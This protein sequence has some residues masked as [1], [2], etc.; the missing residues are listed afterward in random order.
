MLLLLIMSES[1]SAKDCAS[2]Y[3]VHIILF[4]TYFNGIMRGGEGDVRD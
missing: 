2:D 1:K 3:S 4:Y